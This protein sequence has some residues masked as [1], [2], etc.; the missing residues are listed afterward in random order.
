[1]EEERL[2]LKQN[3]RQLARQA[4]IRAAEA[5][6]TGDSVWIDDTG[7]V[8]ADRT[9]ADA[10]I[11]LTRADYDQQLKDHDHNI[12][13]LRRD[14]FDKTNENRALITEIRG[15]EQGLKEIDQQLKQKRFQKTSTGDNSSAYIIQCPSL[16]KMLQVLE[17]QSLAGR[18]DGTMML[19]S[20]ND[21]LLGRIAELRD[22]LYNARHEKTKS[23]VNL[24]LANEPVGH[25]RP[26]SMV[27]RSSSLM[28][29]A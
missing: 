4:G 6:L 5:G 2:K 19:K 13:Q 15:L 25:H 7:A 23:D 3:C 11:L 14:L 28:S 8:R 20:D 16:D 9:V 10:A 1:M 26:I 17:H 29:P 21:Q 22:E 18:Y 24:K 12:D 27:C